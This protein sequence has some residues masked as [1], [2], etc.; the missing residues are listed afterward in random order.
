MNVSGDQAIVAGV[1]LPHAVDRP[2]REKR[3]LFGPATDFFCLGGVYIQFLPFLFILPSKE[4]APT[5]L[6]TTLGIAYF[7]NYPHF[8]FSYQIFYEGFGRKVFG[9][10][11]DAALRMRYIFAGIVSP[12][13]LTAF[14]A[15]G[16]ISGDVRMLGLGANLMI[17][18]VG[19]HYV[20]QGYGMLMVDAALK[21]QYF[22]AS[23]KKL[24]L[25]NSYAVW[26][27]SWLWTNVV[28]S[29]R[30][31]WGIHYYMFH[32][33][34]TVLAIALCVAVATSAA[35]LMML[36]KKWRANDA[37]LPINGVVAYVV[38][39]YLWVLLARLNVLTLLIVPALHS[40]QYLV[41]VARYQINRE[42]DRNDVFEQPRLAILNRLFGGNL[43]LRLAGFAALGVILGYLGFW[44]VP[45]FLQAVVPY[46]EVVFGP[47][48]F[49]FMLWVLINV[50]HYFLDNVMW[51]SQ[52]RDVRKYLFS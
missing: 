43:R 11:N 30:V 41:V 9:P 22:D 35:T 8:A 40:L 51:R 45:E 31:L 47:G 33:P 19:W 2:I 52:N 50:H 39:L 15:Y 6:A 36:V 49:M 7:I 29:E 4:R 26:V 34:D 21:R 17:F 10:D 32:V 18:L 48:L 1:V 3:Y 5:L 37:G 42:R 46:E 20:K 14:F 13:A 27:L 44:G 25:V 38:S 12:V 24:L 28:L 16:L 23:E